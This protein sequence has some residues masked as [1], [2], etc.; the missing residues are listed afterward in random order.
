MFDLF[1]LFNDIS[2]TYEAIHKTSENAVLLLK[3]YQSFVILSKH[4]R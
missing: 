2:N 3:I 4:L 1:I